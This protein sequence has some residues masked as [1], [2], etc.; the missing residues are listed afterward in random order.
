MALAFRNYDKSH[1]RYLDAGEFSGLPAFQRQLVESPSDR[2]PLSMANCSASFSAC[3]MG[4]DGS[5]I[6]TKPPE[7]CSLI[8]NFH[9]DKATL[10]E[11]TESMSWKHIDDTC[12]ETRYF[13]LLLSP[14][15]VCVLHCLITS[16]CIHSMH[17]IAII[18]A[19]VYH[20]TSELFQKLN[21]T[22][23]WMRSFAQEAVSDVFYLN[24]LF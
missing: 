10:C 24:C 13:P 22:K 21:S 4:R 3:F 23:W 6:P 16:R 12:S 14:N 11:N 9:R 2:Y 1:V 17:C 18:E 15:T 20:V 19:N 5:E 8:T 7:G